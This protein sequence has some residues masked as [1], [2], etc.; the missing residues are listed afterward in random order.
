MNTPLE[1]RP[2]HPDD[3]EVLYQQQLDP[4]ANYMAA[5][6]RED[7][8]DRTAY[9]THMARIMADETILIRTI[10]VQGQIAGSVLSYLMEGQ[11]EVSYW[12]G[13]EFWGQGIATRALAAYLQE[14][15]ERPLYARA[16]ADNTGSIRVLEKNGFR[17]VGED[18]YYANA[19]GQEITE[20]IFILEA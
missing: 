12:L 17:R 3:L 16:A 18:R 19:R 15:A 13:R 20:F 7:P 11:R 10:L 2:I 1:L 5:F 6:T 9:E 14:V 4:E 8:T